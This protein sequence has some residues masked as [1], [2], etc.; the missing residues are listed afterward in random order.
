VAEN[1]T[2]RPSYE[3]AYQKLLAGYVKR[4]TSSL[5]AIQNIIVQARRRK[6]TRDDLQRAQH[7]AHGLAGSG[8]TFGFPEITEA[9]RNADTF[10]TKSLSAESSS[11]CGES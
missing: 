7:L 1:E 5:D 4:L 3:N 8:T 9:G 2:A 11:E 6:L 10:L